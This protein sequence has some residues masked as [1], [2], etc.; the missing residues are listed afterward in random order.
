MKE[1]FQHVEPGEFTTARIA[2]FDVGGVLFRFTGGLEALSEL[3]NY[4]YEQCRNIWSELDD[5]VCRGAAQPDEIWKRI[6]Q[7]SG[8]KGDDIDFIRF[9]VGHFQPNRSVHKIMSDLSKNYAIGLMTNIYSNVYEM[10]IENGSIPKLPYAFVLQ[11]CETGV[12]KPDSAMYELAE[13]KSGVPASTILLIDDNM[14]CITPAVSRG[15]AT[16]AFNSNDPD[17]SVASLREGFAL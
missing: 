17:A 14:K 4:P 7:A 15:W 2:V 10:A 3:T 13:Q 1:E 6:K 8:Y 12:V 9:W 16:Y 5:A 11:S